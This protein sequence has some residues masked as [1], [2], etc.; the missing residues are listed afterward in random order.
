MPAR[1]K[2]LITY[3]DGIQM[4]VGMTMLKIY[5]RLHLQDEYAIGLGCLTFALS[6]ELHLAREELLETKK[7]KLRMEVNGPV[8]MKVDSS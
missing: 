8:A 4:D 1:F 2:D 7:P 6:T 5:Q 3:H